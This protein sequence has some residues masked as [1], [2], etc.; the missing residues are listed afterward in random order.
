MLVVTNHIDNA[1]KLTC[2]LNKL[3]NWSNIIT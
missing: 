3:C 2:Y 1:F